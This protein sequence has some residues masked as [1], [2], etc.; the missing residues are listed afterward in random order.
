MEKQRTSART[1]GLGMLAGLLLVVSTG[2][3]ALSAGVEVVLPVD[4]GGIVGDLA[5]EIDGADLT[6]FVRIEDGSLIVLASAA[7]AP[8]AH[9][10][11]IYVR[12]GAGYRIFATYE[13]T[14]DP[15][16][17]RASL[18]LDA[19]HEVGV[20]DDADGTEAYAASSGTLTVE[21]LDQSIVAS[22]TYVADT[23]EENQIAGRFADIAQYSVEIRQNGALLDLVGRLGDQSLGFD[24]ALVSDLNRRG[25]SVEATGP[26]ARLQFTLFALQS[27]A[28]QGAENLLGVTEPDNRLTGARLSFQP[29]FGSDFRISLQGYAGQGAPDFSPFTG[30][31]AGRGVT[32]DGSLIEGRLRYG[33]TWAE[34]EWDGDDAGPLPEDQGQALLA[35][36]G[37]DLL[38]ANGASFTLALDYERVD[39]FYYSLANPAL[40]TG[41]E[42]LRLSADYAAERLTLYGL[43]ET[44]LT[45]QGGD[46]LDPV[47][48]VNRLALDGSWALH[49]AG[50]LTDA[51]LTFGFSVEDLRRVET[52]PAAPPPENWSARTLYLGVEKQG[53]IL[54]WSLVYTYLRE[55]DDGPG[56]FDLTGNELTAT[57]DYAPGDRLTL[58]AIGLAG[59]YDSAFSGEYDRV[60]GDLN[61]NYALDPGRWALSV[62][63]GLQRTNELGVEDGNYAAAGLTRSFANGSELVMNAGWYDGSYSTVVGQA[64]TVLGLTYRV[65]SAMLR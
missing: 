36:L 1:A 21:T 62:D 58:A 44:T 13:F 63:L 57:L 5:V 64:E 45:N 27:G 12:D 22:L 47:D 14:V 6:D 30:K 24:P 46:P 32:L 18:T 7:L 3:P 43:A 49:D 33:V 29:F 15:S 60:E 65:Q 23:R 34:T 2:T 20:T 40:P 16:P 19:N 8:G 10:A 48:R 25:L 9:V 31:G 41:G 28:S 56:N 59:S 61:L 51:I 11:T 42:T 26:D 55:D 39:L 52:P 53:E 37:Y 50:L 4:L 38:P 54:G 17:V 35:S